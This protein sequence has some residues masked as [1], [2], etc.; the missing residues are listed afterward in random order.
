MAQNHSEKSS[1]T[2]GGLSAILASACC[3]GPLVLVSIGLSGV[4]IGQLTRLEPLRPW[5]LIVSML[6]L[7]FAYR[8]IF[9][10]AS[11]CGP[12]QVC[13]TPAVR[14][15]YKALFGIVAALVLIAFGFP[16]AAPW[17]Y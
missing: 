3:L 16:Y 12:D 10:P 2:I 5:F 15:V 14:R 13:A 9:R 8:G 17:F 7:V 1:L 11:A 6:A 4:W